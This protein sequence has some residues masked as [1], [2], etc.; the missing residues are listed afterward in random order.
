MLVEQN[1]TCPHCWRVS[2]I[3]VDVSQGSQSFVQDCEVCCNP[4]E[5]RCTVQQG[6]LVDFQYESA[7]G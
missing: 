6:E 4:I 1:Y 3:V 5:F 7:Q 2:M